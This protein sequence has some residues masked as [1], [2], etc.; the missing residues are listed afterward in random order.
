MEQSYLKTFSNE[1]LN[2]YGLTKQNQNYIT[3]LVEGAIQEELY[4]KTDDF[5]HDL[6]H[7]E[8]VLAYIQMILNQNS[9]F[10]LNKD[11]LMLAG[12]YHDIGKTLGARGKNHGKV[13]AEE[14]IK[15]IENKMDVK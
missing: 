11:T 6:K 4:T 9:S 13:G 7:I 1:Q 10:N 3:N 14:F 8:R 12:F 5:N 2:R 15:R